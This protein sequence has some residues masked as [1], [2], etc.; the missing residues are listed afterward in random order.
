MGNC[1]LLCGHHHRLVHEEGWTVEW[2]GT[3]R[4]AFRS[5][6]GWIEYEGRWKEPEE[7]KDV[8]AET[9]VRNN[10]ALG[11]TPDGWTPSA[12]W[13]REWDIPDELLWRG[14]EAMCGG[15]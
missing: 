12:R 2:W 15:G 4:P 10:R 6:R 9:L 8:S 14:E 7:M 1:L 11:V 5:P 13:K 3:G